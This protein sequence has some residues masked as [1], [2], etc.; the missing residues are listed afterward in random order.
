M[1]KNAIIICDEKDSTHGEY[2]DMCKVYAT[3]Y[4]SLH[5]NVKQ[6]FIDS[7]KCDLAYLD[8][9]EFP[10]HEEKTLFVICSHGSESSFH[11]NGQVK[12]IEDTINVERPLDGGLIYS[13]ACSTGSQFGK[14]IVD[15]KASFLGYEKDIEII[16]NLKEISR[17]CDTYGLYK[18]ISGENLKETKKS[19]VYKYNKEIDKLPLMLGRILK[20]SRDSIVVYGNLDNSFFN[21]VSSQ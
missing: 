21:T 19:M 12:F 4:I 9:V 13:I 11:R 10:K 7:D 20:K 8:I 5:S 14:N 3:A 1:I 16:P 15:K 18:I 6:T 2:F 17:D